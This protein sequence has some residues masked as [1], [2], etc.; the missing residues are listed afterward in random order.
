MCVRARVRM[1]IL[2]VKFN[3]QKCLCTQLENLEEVIRIQRDS[4]T[5]SQTEVK[6]LH[7]KLQDKVNTQ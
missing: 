6:D 7:E 4:L 3:N 2:F 5:M 1:R